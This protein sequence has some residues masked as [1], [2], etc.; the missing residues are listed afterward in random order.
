MMASYYW[1]RYG[2]R[3]HVI[4]CHIESAKLCLGR[5]PVVRSHLLLMWFAL[6][7][8]SGQV[9]LLLL[10]SGICLCYSFVDYLYYLQSIRSVCNGRRLYLSDVILSWRHRS[11]RTMED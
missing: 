6:V 10:C 8:A 3:T 7:V 2:K 5:A 1:L 11:F 4:R 9:Y